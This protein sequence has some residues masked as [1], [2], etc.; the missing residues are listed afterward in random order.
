MKG[1]L[2]QDR[3]RFMAVFAWLFA[4]TPLLQLLRPGSVTK[5]GK[6]YIVNGWI[7]TEKD[8][9]SLDKRHSAI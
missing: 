3:R 2:V 4:T 6:H 9:E 8:L 1:D 5:R 7:L